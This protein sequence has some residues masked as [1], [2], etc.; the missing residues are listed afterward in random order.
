MSEEN[1][2]TCG[3]DFYCSAGK[4]YAGNGAFHGQILCLGSGVT[5][6]MSSCACLQ[7]KSEKAPVRKTK[8]NIKE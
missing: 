4:A 5:C 7:H 2:I 1:I 3:N 8:Q 6:N